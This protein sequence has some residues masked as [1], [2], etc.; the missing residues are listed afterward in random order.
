MTIMDAVPAS[1]SSGAKSSAADL[2]GDSKKADEE[3]VDPLIQ[4]DEDAQELSRLVSND[5]NEEDRAKALYDF[6]LGQIERCRE[7]EEEVQ[8]SDRR[9]DEAGK[10][11]DQNRAEI[12]KAQ[13]A[14]AK[15]ETS[16]KELQRQKES[17]VNENKRIAEE[18]Q[19]RHEELQEKFQQTISDVQEKMD[20]EVQ[21][22]EHFMKENE[23]L[24]VKFAKFME[25]YEAQEQQLEENRAAREMEMEVAEARLNEHEVMCRE[26]R[27]KVVDTQK[28]NERLR[29]SEASLRAQLQTVLGK[30]DEFHKAVTGS[31]TKHTEYKEEIDDLQKKLAELEEENTELRKQSSGSAHKDREVAQRQRDALDKL[32]SNLRSGV[33]KLQEEL[34]ALKAQA[35]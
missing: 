17:L 10:E 8:T 25:T 19:G 31:N 27:T 1:A 33:A 28:K 2:E 23:E 30:F 11:R 15:L 26:S 13:T 6:L 5:A 3:R 34:N 18:E 16:C 29:K 24:Q 21:V 35:S 7:L 12:G 20:A 4:C 22:R 9:Q 14:K 32:C